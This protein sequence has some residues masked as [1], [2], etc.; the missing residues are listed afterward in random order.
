MQMKI[1]LPSNDKQGKMNSDTFLTLAVKWRAC[2]SGKWRRL[3]LSGFLKELLISQLGLIYPRLRKYRQTGRQTHRHTHTEQWFVSPAASGSQPPWTNMGRKT[4]Q[5]RMAELLHAARGG[6]LNSLFFSS[7][8]LGPHY[9][10]V[11]CW[12]DTHRTEWKRPKKSRDCCSYKEP[13]MSAVKGDAAWVNSQHWKNALIPI[14]YWCD[15][16]L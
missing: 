13:L 10:T 11:F 2:V 12:I 3:L 15:G 6:E 9:I 8:G 1:W 5:W 16:A 7:S 4:F 14:W